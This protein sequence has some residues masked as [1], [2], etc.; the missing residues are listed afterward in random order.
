MTK[1][2]EQYHQIVEN[3]PEISPINN[4]ISHL[5][6]PIKKEVFLDLKY[7]NYPK[8]PKAKL[9]K[10]N[11][12][13]NLRRMISSLRDW[14]K[15]SP[16]SMVELIKEIFLL[17]KSVELNQILIKREFLEGLI[18]M[19]QSGHPH[20]LTG[21]LSVNKGIVSE[22]IL[23]SRACTVAEKDF[24]IFR[25]SCSIPLD[26]SYEGTFIS[27]P[28]GELSI[29]E[30]LSKIFKKR[31]FTM[32]LAYPYIDLSCIRCYDSLGNNLELIVMD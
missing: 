26:F 17:I 14:D 6:I 13:F 20:K 32:L 22:F 9:I 28:S 16:L 21:L 12:I 19:C 15:R 18:G 8:E 29:N 3:F 10:G 1:L 5:R 25:P 31:R 2:E 24:E 30:N 11:Q 7:K 23:P 4:S 27:R